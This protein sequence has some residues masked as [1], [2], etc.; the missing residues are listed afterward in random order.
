MSQ[1]ALDLIKENIRT[2]NPKLD[3]G[4]CGVTELYPE[5]LAELAKT[6]E[7]LE[8]LIWSNGWWDFETGDRKYSQNQGKEKWLHQLPPTLPPFPLLRV[9]IAASLGFTDCSPLKGLTALNTLDISSNKISDCSPLKGLTALNTLDISYNQISDCSPLKGLTALNTLDIYNN[10]I[11]DCSPLKGLTALNTL[12][13]SYNQISDCSPLKGLTALNTLYISYNQISDCSPL[14]GLTALNTLDISSN[15]ISDCS[16]LKGLTALNTLYIS[17]NQI[18][19]CSPLEG[20][21]ALNTLYIYNNQISD[22]SPLE[23][24]T[25][26]NK[27]D[28]S[29]NQISDCSPLEGLTAL[30]TLD[31]S[32]NQISQFP[33]MLLDGWPQLKELILFG[34]PIQNIDRAV[35]DKQYTNVL[36]SIKDFVKDLRQGS[37]RVYASKLVLVGNGRVGKTC[38]VKRWLDKQFNEKE[39]T[40][41]AIQ[42]RRHPLNDL[43]AAMGLESLQLNIWDFGGQDIYHATHQVFLKTNALFLLVWDAETEAQA[44]QTETLPDGTIITYTNHPL[45]YWLSYIK[46]LSSN[47]PVLLVQTKAGGQLANPSQPPGITAADWEQF[48][49]RSALAVESSQ[50]VAN[51]FGSL[52]EKIEMLVQEGVQQQCTQLPTSWY[53]VRQQVEQWQAGQRKQVPLDNFMQLCAAN[54]LDESSTQTLLQYLHDTGTLFYK[55]GLFGNQL[56]IDQQ[57]A[58]DAVYALFD[59][60]KPFFRAFRNNGFFTGQH[61]QT[62]WEQYTEAEQELF[63]SFMQRCKICVEVNPHKYN[64]PEKPFVERQFLA[65]QLLPADGAAKKDMAFDDANGPLLI[66]KAGLL[67]PAV[68]QEIIVRLAFLSNRYDMWANGIIIKTDKGKALIEAQETTK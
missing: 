60:K 67:H 65:P 27:L 8:E 56:V 45:R 49:I 24:L 30:N 38:L 12:N 32:D 52:T 7:W 44:V 6:G 2:K 42:L 20:L 33:F 35:Y 25:A 22:C 64:E 10:Q 46:T 31:I 62:Y 26:L 5:L 36:P 68:I 57:W 43:A 58:I 18:S 23:G 13:I 40:T 21:T 1:P 17:Y 59:R 47:S 19:D 28:I 54:G 9:L 55:E 51:G 3:L 41:H 16:P 34:N 66:Y 63:V 11:S 50:T 4:N 14:E 53:L 15:Q 37:S 61:L 39:D 29:N 48:N